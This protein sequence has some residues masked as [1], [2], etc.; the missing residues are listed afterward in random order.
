MGQTLPPRSSNNGLV[1]N[2]TR[3]ARRSIRVDKIGY[4]S[5]LAFPSILGRSCSHRP[6]CP[7]LSE[8][9]ISKGLD[10]AC[11]DNCFSQHSLCVLSGYGLDEPSLA[12]PSKTHGRIRLVKRSLS[13]FPVANS[14]PL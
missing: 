8:V 1:H 11:R 9:I 3:G 13:Y 2:P 14:V 7:K 5:K 4:K 6:C 12:I 10:R